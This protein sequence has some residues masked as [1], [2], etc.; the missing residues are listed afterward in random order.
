MN[1]SFPDNIFFAIFYHNRFAVVK[2][3]QYTVGFTLK[4]IAL[5]F[6]PCIAQITR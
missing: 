3:N 6:K 4:T 2:T 5:L 1:L